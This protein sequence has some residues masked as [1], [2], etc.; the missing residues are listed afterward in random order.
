[1]TA[2]AMSRPPRAARARNDLRIYD[3]EAAAWWDSASPAFRSL[4]RVKDFHLALLARH[5][6]ERLDGR[7]IVDL[8]CGG[9]LLAL[10]LSERGATVIGV[11]SSEGS[12]TAARAEA[13]HAGASCRFLVADLVHTP[14]ADGSADDVVLSD[15]LEHLDTPQ[16][17]IAEASRLLVPGGRLYVNTINRTLRSRC[18]AVSLAE[19]LGLVPRGT[20][21]PALFVRPAELTEFAARAGLRTVR[22]IGEAPRLFTTL[23]KRAI[24][25]RESRSL[26]IAYSAFFVKESF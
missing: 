23:A 24:A 13:R 8:G 14:F 15:V 19:G 9:G 20:H 11:D 25:L 21:D 4:H 6:G 5:W 22:L 7:R 12:V 1:M 16:Q 10:P 3:R 17:A 2:D 26:A 18:I